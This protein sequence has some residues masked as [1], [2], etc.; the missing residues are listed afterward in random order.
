[1]NEELKRERYIVT[2]LALVQIVHIL[3]FVIMMPLGPVFMRDFGISSA[4]FG[5]LVSAYNFS[6]A[7]SAF[8]FTLVADSMERRFSL[9]IFLLGFII[10][11]LLCSVATS[12]GFMMTARITAGFF[13][14]TLNAIVLAIVADI[15]PYQR[16]GNAM[17]IIMSSFSIASVAGVPIGLAIADFS[18]WNYTFGFIALISIIIY[19]PCFKIIPIIKPHNGKRKAWEILYGFGRILTR[20]RYV[21]GYVSVMM[22]SFSSF[23]IIPY[24]SPYLVHNV[25]LLESELKYVYLVGGAFT[26]ISARIIGKM[27]DRYSAQSVFWSLAILS[28]IPITIF[29][30]FGAHSL[31]PTI[32]LT[33]FF[34][35]ILSGRFIPLMTMVSELPEC[36]NERGGF[37]SLQNSLRSLSTAMA[38]LVGGYILVD[39]PSGTLFHMDRVGYVSISLTL[40]TCL[41]VLKIVQILKTRQSNGISNT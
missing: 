37:M 16:R 25:G 35:M 22:I 36:K 1:V 11:T 15:I 4:E 23:I 8:L 3:D 24:I 31:V 39:S 21:W 17:G 10:G 19:I 20:S 14:G 40:L 34:M 2:L 5:Q 9:V 30:N 38:A 12:Y 41:I 7:I 29:T 26:I 6:A 13:G 33:T 18:S 32:A 28:L 27:T